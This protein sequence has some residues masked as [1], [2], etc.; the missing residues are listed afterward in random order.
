MKIRSILKSK[1]R[2]GVQKILWHSGMGAIHDVSLLNFIHRECRNSPNP[3]TQTFESYFSQSDE[4]GIIQRIF[5]RLNVKTGRCVEFGV[6]NGEEN[7]TLNLLL[8]GWETYWFGGEE[9]YFY[10][11]TS[12]PN[13]L[14]FQKVWIDESVL[15]DSIIPQLA[16]LGNVD[17]L[18]LDLDGNDF[19]FARALLE[20]G[21][22]PSVW[23]QEYNGNFSPNTRCVQ[24]YNDKH[25]W[26]EDIY[27]GASLRL[28]DELFTMHGYTLVACNLMGINAFFVRN[29]F[30]SYFEDVPKELQ[31][32]FRPARTLYFK[33]RQNR[34]LQ[35]FKSGLL[36]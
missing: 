30:I 21:I 24:S 11:N 3:L 13:N 9:L 5:Q 28:Y 23:V 7:N 10:R 19:Y 14:N 33:M 26:K 1:F 36:E 20:R 12:L 15:Q 34:S 31:I 4:D 32:L 25:I 27:F 2:K 18:S 29:D 35:I 22:K 8:E 6:G 16:K 17:L